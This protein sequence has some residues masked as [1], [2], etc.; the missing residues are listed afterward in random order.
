M[1]RLG[2]VAV[3]LALAT[4]IPSACTTTKTIVIEITP[5]APTATV[6]APTQTPLPLPTPTL[7]PPPPP[8][9][10]PP[11]VQQP[12]PTA[13][14]AAQEPPPTAPCSPVAV[15]PGAEGPSAAERLRDNYDGILA[16]IRGRYADPF[17]GTEQVCASLRGLS[18][19]QAWETL[20]SRVTVIWAMAWPEF[21][22]DV[23][24]AIGAILKQ[25]CER[26]YP[27]P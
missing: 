2:I 27:A 21:C 20:S 10:A 17:F 14:P 7:I 22:A 15:P 3:G 5:L 1:R 19:Q 6:Q 25:E 16:V 23:E 4:T 24:A 12:P 9:T 13:P 8:P 11:A 18:D 26:M